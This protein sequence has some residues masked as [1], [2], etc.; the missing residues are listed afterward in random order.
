VVSLLEEE[1]AT[2]LGLA[3]EDQ[4][5]A[6]NGIRF[7]RF[8]ISD[9]GVPASTQRAVAVLKEIAEAP[10]D[11]NHVAV[12]CRQGIGRSGLIAAG[13][14]VTAGMSADKAIEAVSATRGQTVPETAAQRLWIH[15]LLPER[16][17]EAV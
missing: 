6:S 14:L 13:A 16:L 8:P 17:A 10:E 11:G 4:A 5:A 3:R 2:Q 12:H 1:E 9:R 7:V 15:Q